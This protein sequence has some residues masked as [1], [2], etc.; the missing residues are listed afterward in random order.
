[1]FICFIF[2]NNSKNLNVQHYLQTASFKYKQKRRKIKLAAIF[3]KRE[4]TSTPLKTFKQRFKFILKPI[5]T[6]SFF[7]SLSCT[8]LKYNGSY[9]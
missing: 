6:K 3:K 2:L 9:L 4:Y 1:M 7:M 8:N 5:C